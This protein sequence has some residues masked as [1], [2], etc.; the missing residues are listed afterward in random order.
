MQKCAID[1][2]INS[3]TKEKTFSSTPESEVENLKRCKFLI[4]FVCKIFNKNNFK[5]IVFLAFV[6]DN[7]LLKVR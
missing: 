1:S 4:L 6:G 7:I 5:L 2:S 3:N